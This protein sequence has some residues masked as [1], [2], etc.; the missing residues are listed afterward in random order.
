MKYV[1]G[2]IAGAA[3]VL[4]IWWLGFD[5]SGA[6]EPVDDLGYQLGDW[7]RGKPSY[8]MEATTDEELAR[9]MDQLARDYAEGKDV[10]AI[11]EE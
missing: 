2:F 11:C 3:A 6:L 5:A 8:C 4:F 7:L 9:A 10:I 1:Y